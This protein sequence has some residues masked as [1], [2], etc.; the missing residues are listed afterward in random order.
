[1]TIPA[2]IGIWA[3]VTVSAAGAV[4][5]IL[6][7]RVPNWLTVPAAIAGLGLGA[8]AGGW[9]GIALAASGMAIGLGLGVLAMLFGAPFGGGDAKLLAAIGALAGIPFL[10]SAACYGAIAGGLIAIAVA[11]GTGRLKQAVNA[12]VTFTAAS[13]GRTRPISLEAVSTGLTIPFAVALAAGAI[14]AAILPPPWALIAV[15]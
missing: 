8:V 11:L 6:W 13:A 12:I 7:R 2:E 10:A 4:T 1:M 14:A 9:H 15:A 3:A 5:D